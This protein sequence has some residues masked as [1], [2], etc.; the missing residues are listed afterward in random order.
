[1]DSS[2]HSSLPGE[3]PR[4]G[5]I[6]L[7][8][9]RPI[10]LL[11]IFS[12]VA[13]FG[14]IS[15]RRLPVDLMPDVDLPTITVRTDVPGAAP[16]DV[17]ERVSR[18]LEEALSVVGGLRRI[19]SISRAETCDVILEFAWDSDL[20]SAVQDIREKLDQAFLPDD[21]GAPTVLRYDPRLEPILLVGLEGPTDLSTLRRIAEE[22]VERRL[23][24]VD[25]IA[26]VRVRG[27]FEEEIGILVDEDHLRS[28][29]VSIARISQRLAEENLDQAAGQLSDGEVRYI[30]RTRNEL[31]TLDEILA[32]PIRVD[33][34]A[35]VRLSDV[36]TVVSRPKEERVITR[37]DGRPAVQVEILRE[38]DANIVELSEQVRNRLFGTEK[39]Q[40]AFLRWLSEQEGPIP[41]APAS[42]PTE[43]GGRSGKQGSRE[44]MEGMPRTTPR[45]DY[46]ASW[47][48]PDTRLVLLSDQSVFIEGAIR[49]LQQTAILGG[50]LAI[51]VLF[52]F[53]GRLS[54]TAVVA[55]TIPCSVIATFAPMHLG[56]I[57]LNIMSLGGLA[58]GIGM[59]VD[60]SIVVLESIFRRQ[61]DGLGAVEAA[62]TGAR[63]VAPA[64]MAS[65]LTTVAVF[66]PIVFVEG[67][68]GRLFRDQALTVVLSL[69][70]SLIVALT[71]IPMLAARLGGVG[72]ASKERRALVGFG[73]RFWTVHRV[74]SI[75]L[76]IHRGI[77]LRWALTPLFLPYVLVS[78][79]IDFF[80][81]VIL[82][83][84]RAIQ[85]IGWSLIRA[86]G[87]AGA[88]SAT[89]LL[90]VFRH[91]YAWL[92]DLYL[93]G[94][95]VALDQRGPILVATAGAVALSL[96][97][98]AGLGSELVPEASR[99]E[100]TIHVDRKSVV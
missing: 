1:M 98:V 45:P 59:L 20:R 82:L 88:Y 89:P 12:A 93:R 85:L 44:G 29:G 35:I 46:I 48:P 3:S 60:S 5:V 62:I 32:L 99:G 33:G 80:G 65:T 28:R 73:G 51:F 13:V 9:R 67:M 11:M 71:L 14:L 22:E 38:G 30:V 92:E 57:S 54:Y 24:T 16:G 69:L 74:R 23:E 21:A 90:R 41:A 96:W 37:I 64:V 56:G 86:A 52:L 42:D 49:D 27:G 47:L 100:F 95:S 72:G 81:I 26:A 8:V 34:E 61:E 55:V 77:W 10:A 53:L 91:G 40:A 63:E 39:E 15:L 25:G 79:L 31:K 70:A 50:V 19:T 58:L 36:A 66:F 2:P 84:R 4:K 75:L 83:S 76:W 18:R 17:E 87:R 68:A 43:T 94:I 78:A 97:A 7:A 6:E